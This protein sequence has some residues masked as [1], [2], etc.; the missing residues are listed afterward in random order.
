MFKQFLENSTPKYQ[1]LKKLYLLIHK[2]GPITKTELI[3]KTKIKKTTLVRMID[4]LLKNNFIKESGYGES[5]VGRPP[6]LY[7]VESDNYYLIG[8]HIS[9]MKTNIVLLN[10]KYEQID[11]EIFVMTSIHTPEFVMMKIKDIIQTFMEVHHFDEKKLLGIGIATIVPLNRSEGMILEPE[12]YLAAN[13]KNV[14]IVKLVQELFSVK[15]V[16]E[17]GVNAGAI[18]EY[19]AADFVHENILYCVSG[20]WGLD[21]GVIVNGQVLP[22]Y[23]ADAVGYGHMIVDLEGKECSCG[24]R[25]CVIAYTSFKSIL[26]E[27][28]NE[29]AMFGDV[30]EELFQNASIN[31]LMEYF[32]QGNKR[33]ED[34]VLRSAKY[35][36][37]G[38]SNS[39]NLFRSKLVV[40]NGPLI[41]EFRGYYNQVVEHITR[42]IQEKKE[43][44]FTKG[45][46][47]ENAPAVGAAILLF[48][49][50][51]NDEDF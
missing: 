40:L 50:Y 47:K 42:N 6:I 10:L 7:D 41:Y 14:P 2:F 5:T 44:T 20:S 1:D 17:K 33:T 24:K 32:K 26:R 39:L 12:S 27:L 46:L 9:R 48:Q 18:A 36:G 22:D 11:Q 15:V 29:D 37:I 35:L 43:V 25:G 28:K 45:K 19:H 34:I 31:D 30:S 21:C 38:L 51:F 16:L 8:L 13:W 4:E 23:Y 3:E 49:S